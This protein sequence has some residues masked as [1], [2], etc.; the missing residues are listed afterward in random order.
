[1]RMSI[2]AAGSHKG[3][4]TSP[5]RLEHDLSGGVGLHALVGQS[6]ARD[7]AAQLLQRLAIIGAAAHGGM[8]GHLLLAKMTRYLRSRGTA[9]LAGECLGQSGAMSQL[10]AASH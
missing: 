10:G 7:V 8:Q 9:L 5:S 3:A 2:G 1:M 4:G 6:G